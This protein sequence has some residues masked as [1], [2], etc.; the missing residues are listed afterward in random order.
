MKE[1]ILKAY[2]GWLTKRRWREQRMAILEFNRSLA[3]IADPEGLTA[4][5]AVRF[6]EIFGT[7]RIIVLR[8]TTD[9]GIFE[10]KFSMG[11]SNR[12]IDIRLSSRDRLAKW[13]FRNEAV[14]AVGSNQSVISSLSDGEREML[15]DLDI[16][17]CVP[18]LALNRLT[19]IMLLSSSQKNWSPSQDDYNLIQMLMNQASFAFENAYLYEQQRDRLRRLYRAERLA[20]AGQLAASVAHEIRNPLTA[21]RSTVQYLLGEYNEANP[22]RPLVE[23]LIS[24][25]DRIDRTLDGLLSITRRKEFNIEMV[26]LAQVV[27][28]TLLL[29]RTQAQLNLVEIIWQGVP[30]EIYIAGD[31]SQVKQLFLN[32]I[33]NALQAMPDGGS[34]EIT[35]S[36]SDEALGLTN[37]KPQ[38]NV[39]IKD[40]GYGIP[41]EILDKIFDPF[42]TTKEV[43]TVLGLPTCYAITRQHGGELEI[44]SNEDEG[45]TVALKFPLAK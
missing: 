41:T 30:Q 12:D 24:E 25:V 38:A 22:K 6:A 26:A 23:G 11:W 17:V 18:L 35:I 14:L 36:Q 33:L 21:I 42:F 44:Y 3:L 43:G 31:S 5:I 20:T 4:S 7:D 32:L 40:T 19:G 1:S 2:K 28:D 15:Q 27:E 13:L 9:N 10:V 37:D 34:L 39:K 16:R 45:T 29:M 8:A